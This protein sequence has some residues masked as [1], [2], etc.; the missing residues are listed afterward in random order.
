MSDTPSTP[1]ESLWQRARLP[2]LLIA[3]AAVLLGAALNHRA[4]F[5]FLHGILD[6]LMPLLLG[7]ILA[8]ILN[9]PMRGFERLVARAL[10]RLPRRKKTG[11]KPKPEAARE[12]AAESAAP[13]PTAAVTIISLVLTLLAVLLVLAL[14]LGLVVPEVVRSVRTAIPIV[15]ERWPLL[16][17]KLESYQIDTTQIAEWAAKLDLSRLTSSAGILFGSVRNLASS[18][19]S[20]VSNIILGLVFA[21]YMLLGKRQLARQFRRL[22]S[23][24]LKPDQY[25]RLLDIAALVQQTYAR[26][27]TSQGLEALILGLMI[28]TGFLA[29]RLPYALL[30]AVLTAIFAFVPFVGALI[31]AATG[32]I[33]TLFV[34][35]ERVWLVIVVYVV[36]QFIE[37]Q[38][39]YPRVVGGSVGLSPLWTLVAA[40]LGGKLFGLAGIILSIPLASVLY[41]LLRQNTNQKLRH[42]EEHP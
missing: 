39:V 13:A 23:A 3:S 24:H 40:L 1:P 2:L 12:H 11:L 8:F 20:L 30:V 7:A 15:Q 32:A 22:A 29:F 21:I 33:L 38:F 28:F 14:A 17:A 31:A 25:H 4:F 16:L 18:T 27:I 41:T 42:K 35:P 6:L 5:T 9:V 26:F 19:L 36:I 37:N 34:A 10:R